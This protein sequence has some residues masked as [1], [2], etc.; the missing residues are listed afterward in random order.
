M[1]R[2]SLITLAAGGSAAL[3]IAAFG[4]QYLGY[5]PCKLCLWQRW[6]H[7]AAIVLGLIGIA[8]P[9]AIVVIGGAAAAATTALIGVYHTGVERS[10]WEGPTSCSGDG[11]DLLGM[12]GGDL[13]STAI[14]ETVVMCDEVAWWFAGLSMAS[15]NA[16]ASFCLVLIWL[17]AL[18]R[19]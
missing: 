18:R 12:S 4:F 17:A 9:L 7:G 10:W 2:R 8:A 16:I 14:P 5:A 15:W 1:T 11:G 6:P 3:L 19:R 13:L